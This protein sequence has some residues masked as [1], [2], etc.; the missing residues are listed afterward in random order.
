MTS[1]VTASVVAP[2]APGVHVSPHFTCRP[3]SAVRP[4]ARGREYSTVARVPS[5]TCDT[6][7][8]SLA[9]SW[10]AAPREASGRTASEATTAT[11]SGRMG[12]PAN[13]TMDGGQP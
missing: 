12:A 1:F 9:M 2:F 11:A 4:R 6:E 10:A 5:T 8:R 7:A 13:G 3:N